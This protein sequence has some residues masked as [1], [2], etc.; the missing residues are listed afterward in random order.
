MSRTS[1]DVIYMWAA[2][3]TIGALTD[4]AVFRALTDTG[5]SV[6]EAAARVSDVACSWLLPQVSLSGSLGQ[7]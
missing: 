7:P 5:M 3:E 4:F 2:V 6:D 1:Y